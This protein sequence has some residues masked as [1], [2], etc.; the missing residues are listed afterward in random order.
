MAS[1]GI[2]PVAER[3]GHVGIHLGQDQPA[4]GPGLLDGG[5]QDVH[6]DPEGD[7]AVARRRRVD[8]DGVGRAHRVEEPGHQRQPHGQVV[9]HRARGA[10]PGRRTAS[11]R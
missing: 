10:C 2:S 6:L 11:R 8:Q 3:V 1:S 5:G 4:A 9:E 7:L